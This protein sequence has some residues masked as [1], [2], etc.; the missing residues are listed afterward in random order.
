MYVSTRGIG[1][2][3]LMARASNGSG[4][5]VSFVKM[6]RYEYFGSF[7]YVMD[8]MDIIV[9]YEQTEPL[10]RPAGMACTKFLASHI[11]PRSARG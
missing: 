2:R 8:P 3:T 7:L 5:R 4:I 10:R 6:E 1:F 11:H 9:M